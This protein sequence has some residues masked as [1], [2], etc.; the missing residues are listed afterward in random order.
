MSISALFRNG[1]DH[2]SV[3]LREWDSHGSWHAGRMEL[4]D[5]WKAASTNF[6]GRVPAVEKQEVRLSG[7]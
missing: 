7:I 6:D 4:R 2:V 1:M 3:A 5:G